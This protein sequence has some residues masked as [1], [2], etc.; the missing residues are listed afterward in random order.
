MASRCGGNAIPDRGERRRLKEKEGATDRDEREGTQG[1]DAGQKGRAGQRSR[2]AERVNRR[3][4]GGR[5]GAGWRCE[6]KEVLIVYQ[7]LINA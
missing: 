4:A 6:G 1:G 7:K 5:E 2:K 3:G